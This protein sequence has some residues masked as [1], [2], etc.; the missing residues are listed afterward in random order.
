[1]PPSDGELAVDE[2][3]VVLPV[4]GG[5]GEG[6]LQPRPLV[7]G[8]LVVHGFLADLLRQQ[9]EQALLADDR[10]PVVQEAQ[11]AVQI[12]VVAQPLEDEL[13]IPL[14]RRRRSSDPG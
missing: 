13:V 7:V 8:D 10:L 6:E 2:A 12:R 3:E 9:V 14:V 11:A 1:M 5:V 4:V